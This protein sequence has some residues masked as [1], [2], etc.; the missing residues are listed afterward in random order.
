MDKDIKVLIYEKN[1]QLVYELDGDSLK[2]TTAP[3][4]IACTSMYSYF[5]GSITPE[6]LKEV[7]VKQ[8]EAWYEYCC[9]YGTSYGKSKVSFFQRD[10]KVK[11]E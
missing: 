6:R 2:I 1:G 8:I 7:L 10:R 3:I 4:I 9:S 11:E 5:N